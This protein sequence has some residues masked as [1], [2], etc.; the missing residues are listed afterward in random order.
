[1]LDIAGPALAK[2]P[3]EDRMGKAKAAFGGIQGSEGFAILS[4]KAVLER[5]HRLEEIMK[6]PTVKAH[7]MSLLPDLQ[8]GSTVQNARST[9]Q[10]FNVTMAELGRMTLPAVNEALKNF[11][12]TLEALR[13]IIPGG[14]GKSAAV[15]GG[16][17]LLGAAAGV[18]TGA[19]IGAFGGPVGALGGAAIGAVIGGTEGV[20]EQYMEQQAAEAAK[21]RKEGGRAYER[22]R[23]NLLNQI[24]GFSL[25]PPAAPKA[26][27]PP[28]TLNLDVDG[29]RLAQVV[30]NAMGN[31]N[32]FP[33]QAPADDGLG[34]FYGGDH[35]HTDK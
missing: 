21:A 25:A 32:E 35:Q 19:L 15:V 30:T 23:D 28:I 6:D 27:L 7:Y 4:N 31:P 3:M 24:P 33:T 9:L 11:K 12:S 18:G 2:I 29:K 16:H 14:D 22:Y 1:M 13:S 5:V 10:E 17:A 8:A 34:Q 26:V 20:A